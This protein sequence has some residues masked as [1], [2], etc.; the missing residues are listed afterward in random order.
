MNA[1]RINWLA[2]TFSL[3]V[4]IIIIAFNINIIERLS[5]AFWLTL[6]AVVVGF[7]PIVNYL[8]FDVIR[9]NE[10]SEV[11]PLL[12][13]IPILTALFGWLFLNQ[14][15]SLLALGGIISICASIYCLQLH[16]TK[17]WFEPFRA[18]ASS[19][20]ARSMAVISLITAVAAI[21]DKYAIER[22]TTAIYMALNTAGAILVL[23]VCDLIFKNRWVP[24]IRN[25]LARLPGKQWLL[26]SCLGLVQ[27]ATQ[28]S[29]FI[30]VNVS[31]NTSY[32]VAIRNLN[33]VAASL[34][35]LVLYH[36]SVNRYKFISYGLSALGVVMI[37]L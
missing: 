23:V 7:Y 8:F 17:K 33:I 11:L 1:F 14:D 6:V 26:I 32:T 9:R 4:I 24:S 36:E 15:P 19:R 35:A 31:S 28:T 29:G 3:P 34:V 37:A 13:L 16:R 12:G 18:L 25:E 10:L 22:S 20:S 27:L 5:S 2:F 30:A 21:G